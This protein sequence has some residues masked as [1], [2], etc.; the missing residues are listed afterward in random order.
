MVDEKGKSSAT[1]EQ[2]KPKYQGRRFQGKR[3]EGEKKEHILILR[4]GKGNNYYQF[5]QALYK[6]ALKDYGDLAKLI[7]Q[8][9]Y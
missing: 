3:H 7:I 9:K 1:G 8:N 2:Q 5:Q 6:K 4:Y